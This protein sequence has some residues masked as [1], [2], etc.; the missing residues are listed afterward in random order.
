MGLTEW[1]GISRRCIG[2]LSILMLVVPGAGAQQP[3]TTTEQACADAVQ[4]KVAWNQSGSRDWV[5]ANL[6]RLCQG[7]VNPGATIAC[8]EA[9][10]RSHGAWARAIDECQPQRIG[11]T[12]APASAAAA[13]T[14]AAPRV[15]AP[16]SDWTACAAEG[17]RCAFRG[18]AVVRYGAD[19]KFVVRRIRD[20][21]DCSN[22]AFGDPAP[23]VPKSCAVE[24]GSRVAGLEERMART[25]T[26]GSLAG[27]LT[28]EAATPGPTTGRAVGPTTSSQ[29]Y[30]AP[31]NAPAPTYSAPPNAPA[32]TYSAPPNAPAPTYAAPPNA[33]A[34]KPSQSPADAQY[35]RLELKPAPPSEYGELKLKPAPKSALDVPGVR[36][37]GRAG[38]AGGAGAGATAITSLAQGQSVQ[39][40]DPSK[41]QVRGASKDLCWV[42]SYGNGAGEVQNGCPPG[43][44]WRDSMCYPKCNPGETGSM[45]MCK[46]ECP[47]GYRTDPLTCWRDA[48]II[49]A[50]TSAC[51]GHD[52]CGV[53]LARGCSKCP[54]GYKN[55]GCTCRVDADVRPR[56][57]DVGIGVAG[58]GC[59]PG[60]EK[61][62]SGLFCYPKCKPGYHMVGP[63]C[64][65]DTCTAEYPVKCGLSCAVSKDAC[66]L[67][68]V[69]QVMAPIQVVTNVLGIVV[70][71][72]ASTA[73]TAAAKTAATGAKVAA[74]A[75]GQ[76]A[77]KETMK[78]AAKR[79]GK[80]LGE[81]SLETA[82]S[83]FASAELTGSFSWYDLDPTGVAGVVE[84]Y[85]K[86]ICKA[87]SK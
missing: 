16:P 5:P 65:A 58:S 79:A 52:V 76:A 11:A 72:G 12:Q 27:R 55:D 81:A 41:I 17:E 59:A 22:A 86:P 36:A 83:T 30:G 66:T 35:G 85:N 60:V 62:P 61:D 45:T 87:P 77:I 26:I 24:P 37:V 39:L 9:G 53:T 8:F 6:R 32:P 25:G 70:T 31:P 18:E 7:T 74:K 84:V 46:S 75:A 51:P 56:T 33:P 1:A 64:W 28:V 63:V 44:E 3:L 57:R 43:R 48:N 29:I 80:E 47:S 71:G 13:A 49:S 38:V 42:D 2:L 40:Q 78:A 82:S 68:I 15:P 10:V 54:P 34:P 19:D 73:V 21:V 23:G 69:S 67:G 4:G 14:V 50:D 20:G